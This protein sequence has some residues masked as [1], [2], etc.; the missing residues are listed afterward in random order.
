MLLDS[1]RI[2]FFG[3]NQFHKTQNLLHYFFQEV[4]LFLDLALLELLKLFY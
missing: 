1:F 4:N 3:E 2:F